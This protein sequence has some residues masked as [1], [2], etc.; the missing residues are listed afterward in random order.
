MKERDQ[1]GHEQNDDPFWNVDEAIGEG[2]FQGKPA[3]IRLRAHIAP[4]PYRLET[5]EI[6]PLRAKTG[7]RLYVLAKPY[8]LKPDISL[9]IALY[10]RPLPSGAIG[11][12]VDSQW[13]GMRPVEVGHAQAWLY[14]ED[15]TLIVWECLLEDRYRSADPE[16]DDTLKALW[17][18]F[19]QFLLRQLPRPE[20]MATPS[21]EPIYQTDRWRAFLQ[22]MGYQPGNPLAF[23]KTV[24]D[25]QGEHPTPL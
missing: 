20:R 11:T 24:S 9:T 19:E 8:I 3:M 7:T 13:E 21:W 17:S 15:C 12:V 25:L 4:E 22:S 10:P 14:P 18:G 16:S 6:I 2:S 1:G 5:R 23:V